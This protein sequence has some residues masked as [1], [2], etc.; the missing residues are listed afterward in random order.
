MV[1]ILRSTMLDF[2]LSPSFIIDSWKR[3]CSGSTRIGRLCLN[4]KYGIIYTEISGK[5]KLKQIDTYLGCKVLWLKFR[6]FNSIIKLNSKD[7][8]YP[9]KFKNK[10]YVL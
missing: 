7:L 10:G 4:H 6:E 2:N 3:T 8:T 5:K 1:T 9:Q